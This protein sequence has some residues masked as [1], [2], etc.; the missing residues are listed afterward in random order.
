[1]HKRALWEQTQNQNL[2]VQVRRLVLNV[3]IH[4]EEQTASVLLTDEH[5]RGSQVHYHLGGLYDQPRAL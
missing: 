1:M 5:R 4:P 3:S 2:Q